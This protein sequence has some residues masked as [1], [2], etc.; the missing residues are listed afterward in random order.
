MAALVMLSML[1][2]Q[3]AYALN[4]ETLLMPGKVSSAHAKYEEDCSQC[5]IRSDRSKQRARCLDCHKPIAQDISQKRGFHGR[6]PGMGAAECSSCH[7]EHL[8]RDADIV[9][10]SRATFDHA[11]TDFHL[12]GAHSSLACVGCH[13]AGKPLR[14]APTDCKACHAKVEPHDGK[15]GHDCAKCHNVNTWQQAKFD[16]KQTAFALNGRHAE[17]PCAQCHLG[18]RFKGTPKQC[19][20]C[21]APDDVHRGERGERCAECHSESTWKSATFDHAKQTG[22]A[23]L[24]AH[25]PLACAA[26]HRT[27]QLK[28]P[29]PKDCRGCHLGQDAHAGRFGNDCATCHANTAWKPALFDHERDGH[30]PL[31]G[32]HAQVQCHACHTGNIATQKL[33]Q[34][35]AGCHRGNDVHAGALGKDCAQCHSPAGWRTDVRFDHDFTD[36]PLLGLHVTV[37]CEQ[38]HVTR[39]YK[40]EPHDCYA[41]HA[42]VDAHQGSLGRECGQCHSTNGWN[43]WEFDHGKQ[44]GFALTGAH[45]TLTCAQCHRQPA[46]EVKLGT[47]CVACHRQDDIHLGQFGNQCERCHSTATFKGASRR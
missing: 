17:L 37:P 14:S 25:A 28:D 7:S 39:T 30:W 18:N 26:C 8:G 13:Q 24:G 42:A 47:A 9:R 43:I 12:E 34:D 32:R 38:C 44:S 46:G 10:F 33:K 6:A 21:H 23:L 4:P 29:V 20:S 36:F 40:G 15:L 2:M 27:G 3:R 1:S 16:H 19:A 22:F 11:L 31:A 35:C 5:H 45:R 41:C